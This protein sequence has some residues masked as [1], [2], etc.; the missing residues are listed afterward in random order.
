MTGVEHRLVSDEWSTAALLGRDR[1]IINAPSS[2]DLRRDLVLLDRDGTL[3]RL[4]P[5]YVT[6]PDNLDILPGAAEAVR[7]LNERGVRVVLV[8]NQRGL[9]RGL[10]SEEQLVA[11]H[12]RLLQELALGG[13]YLD[14]IHVCGHEEGT[15]DCRK[16]L[17]GLIDQVLERAPWAKRARTVLVGDSARDE[18]AARNA[19][20]DFVRIE[21]S[22]VGLAEKI[23]KLLVLCAHK[24]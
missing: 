20:I 7:K 2:A 8:T 21:D 3:N 14:G 18:G 9:A 11:V 1:S 12:R 19:Q 22:N 15:C 10:L 24:A 4:R 17:P 16:P 23:E 13:A 6:N 5:G